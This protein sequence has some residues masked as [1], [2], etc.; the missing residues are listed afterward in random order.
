MVIQRG[1]PE[2]AVLDLILC[3][4]VA[5]RLLSFAKHWDDAGLEE[6]CTFGAVCRAPNGNTWHERSIRVGWA[7]PAE[8]V[9]RG[10][11]GAIHELGLVSR[12]EVVCVCVCV[13]C[14][15]IYVGTIYVGRG[16]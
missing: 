2:L 14:V 15:G 3:A 12:S 16:V 10:V 9:E 1:V 5:A 11:R 7:Q 8:R 4:P 6:V 13:G